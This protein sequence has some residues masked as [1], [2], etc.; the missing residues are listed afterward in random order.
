MW[1]PCGLKLDDIIGA[2]MTG[3]AGRLD[4]VVKWTHPNDVRFIERERKVY[5]RLG[6]YHGILRYFGPVENGILLEFAHHGSI[7]QYRMENAEATPLTT[8]LRWIQQVTSTICFLHSKGILHADISCNNIF[9]DLDLNAKVADFA[10]SVIDREPY[11]CFYEAS[12]SHPNIKGVCV[13]SEIFALGSTFYEILTGFKPYPNLS[14]DEIEK[15]YSLD[16]FPPLDG[17]DICQSIIS[18]CWERSYSGVESLLRDIET[19]VEASKTK[20]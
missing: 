11:L 9:L 20:N 4:A 17:L 7:R 3:Y 13:Q 19:E 12:Y 15:S 14:I 10:G 16:E 8:K 6:S 1:Y 18:K 2:G 5:E